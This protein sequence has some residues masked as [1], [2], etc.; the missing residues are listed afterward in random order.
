MA[1]L[2]K[3]RVR[4]IIQTRP[5]GTTPEGIVA[6]LREQGH[7]LEGYANQPP[8]QGFFG[9]VADRFRRSFGTA[10]EQAGRQEVKGLS[11]G[12]G[13]AIKD[14]PGDI[15]DIAGPALPAIGGVVG[16]II[17]ASAGIPSGPGAIA[18]GVAGGATGAA[19]GE[20]GR[21]AAGRLLGMRQGETITEEAK[22]IGKEAAIGAASELGGQAIARPL[23]A[24][25]GLVGKAAESLYQS[26]LKPTRAV[27]DKFPK[28]VQ[29]GLKEGIV[30]SEG[31]LDVVQGTID[32][33]NKEIATRIS[34][35]NK[36]GVEL[37]TEDVISRL[38]D[39]RQFFKNS[40]GGSKFVK[41]IDALSDRF[42]REQGKRI[43][44]EKAQELKKNTYSM[45][46]KAYGDMKGAEI[47][48]TKA[49]ARGLKEEIAG[50]VP[51]IGNLNA[52]ESELI[53]LEAA[54]EGFARRFGNREIF[55]LAPG[56]ALGV[57]ANQSASSGLK[58][59]VVAKL[60]KAMIDK[61]QIKSGLAILLDRLS[62]TKGVS[63]TTVKILSQAAGQLFDSATSQ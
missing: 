12:L 53:G 42:V 6:A 28:V 19:I 51:E 57:G 50:V 15:A 18:T 14:I 55:G 49:I 29:T 61:P 62:Q 11:E 2:S 1:F 7:Q 21:Q 25:K 23:S 39:V 59:G 40:I 22:R 30:V 13:A 8:P 43:P 5:N 58:A 4:Q 37:A 27:L 26:A 54:L 32:D 3:D 48:G 31:G 41:Q 20:V 46:R 36:E 9:N 44:I 24:A 47:E 34:T 63:D 17:G 52:R 45:L 60:V 56:V 35:A 16:S 38:E 33:L 10:E